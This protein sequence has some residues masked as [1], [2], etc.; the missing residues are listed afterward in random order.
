M[1][2]LW[3]WPMNKTSFCKEMVE[4]K[5]RKRKEEKKL[6]RENVRIKCPACNLYARDCSSIQNLPPPPTP[7]GHRTLDINA[8]LEYK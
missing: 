8:N 3:I 7:S 2:L 6:S 5:N 4:L 1:R